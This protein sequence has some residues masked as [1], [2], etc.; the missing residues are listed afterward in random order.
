[1]NWTYSL[2]RM[3]E[4]EQTLLN[5]MIH[6]LSRATGK[7]ENYLR[8]QYGIDNI[9]ETEYPVDKGVDVE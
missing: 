7:S 3:T 8:L 9:E 4:E 1:M 5:T 6:E 2:S